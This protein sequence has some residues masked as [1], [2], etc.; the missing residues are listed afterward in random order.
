MGEEWAE[1]AR[2]MGS[3]LECQILR[4]GEKQHKTREK[5]KR[6]R[7]MEMKRTRKR[8]EREKKNSCKDRQQHTNRQRNRSDNNVGCSTASPFVEQTENLK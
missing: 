3:D 7:E 1:K 5:G 4:K 2:E 6:G 8:E